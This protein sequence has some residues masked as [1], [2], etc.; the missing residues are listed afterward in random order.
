MFADRRLRRSQILPELALNLA[1]ADRQDNGSPMTRSG[2][3]S[4]RL[5]T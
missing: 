1:P 5:T 2:Y 4:D 3:E